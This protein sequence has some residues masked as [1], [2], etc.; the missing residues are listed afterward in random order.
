ML[1]TASH[2]GTEE[3]QRG[4]IMA[5]LPPGRKIQLEDNSYS[6]A[7]TGLSNDESIKIIPGLHSYRGYIY[8]NDLN[9]SFFG[10]GIS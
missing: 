6:R 10:L 4:E 7:A 3:E 2:H 8:E 9:T 5:C 1:G